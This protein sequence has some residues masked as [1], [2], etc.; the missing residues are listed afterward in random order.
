M[1][2]PNEA[3]T[4]NGL[5]GFFEPAVLPIMIGNNGSTQG[6]KIVR[7]PAMKELIIRVVFII[8]FLIT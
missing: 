7:I 2:A 4:T 6:A 5:R 8:F 1:L 3:V